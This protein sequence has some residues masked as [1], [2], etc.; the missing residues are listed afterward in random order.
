MPYLSIVHNNNPPPQQQ[1]IDNKEIKF[2]TVIKMIVKFDVKNLR[3]V[4]MTLK[5][6]LGC[7]T[8]SHTVCKK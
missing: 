8:T 3:I 5:Y 1:K 4:T 7:N 2:R 6:E